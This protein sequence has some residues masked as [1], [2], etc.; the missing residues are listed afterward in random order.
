MQS[1]KKTKYLKSKKASYFDLFFIAIFLF[2]SALMIFIGFMVVSAFNNKI[3]AQSDISAS[4]KAMINDKITAKYPPVFDKLYLVMFIGSLLTALVGAWMIDTHPVFFVVGIIIL[5]VICII[6]MVLHNAYERFVAEPAFSSMIVSFP[7]INFFM[8]HILQIIIACA[9][10]VMIVLYA[11]PKQ[12][13][14]F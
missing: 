10:L 6:T 9:I 12:E 14:T 11:K 13:A 4:T 1:R 3:Q 2:I 8:Q 7:I 5:V